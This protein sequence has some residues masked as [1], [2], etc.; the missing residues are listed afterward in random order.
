[1]L[2]AHASEHIGRLGSDR[3][4]SPPPAVHPGA[5]LEKMGNVVQTPDAHV[6]QGEER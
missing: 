4:A 2:E 6:L 5:E 1:M 3:L